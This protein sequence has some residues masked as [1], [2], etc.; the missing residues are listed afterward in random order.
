MLLV[1][2]PTPRKGIPYLL[3][4]LSKIRARRQDFHLNIVGEGPNRHEYEELTAKLGLQSMITF[5]GRQPEIVSFMRE[6][7][8]F[9]LPSLYE[10]FGVVYIEAMACGKP[11]IATN[12]GGPKEIVNDEVGILVPPKDVKA[13][14]KAI[15]YM[16]DNYKNYSSEKI[17]QYAK[18]RFSHRTV[19]QM[20][21]TV[22]REVLQK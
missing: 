8:F 2:I 14:E 3:E 17:A 12:A 11:V 5:H 18:E 10:N 4:V 22:Y 9:V 6:C 15:E 7:D 21:D 16:L 20:I 1:G 13:L 19:G